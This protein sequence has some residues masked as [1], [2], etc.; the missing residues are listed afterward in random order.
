MAWF[1]NRKSKLLVKSA[2]IRSKTWISGFKLLTS[3]LKINE[4]YYKSKKFGADSK[5]KS[6]Y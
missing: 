5:A 2:R 3:D 1:W 4:D 6:I